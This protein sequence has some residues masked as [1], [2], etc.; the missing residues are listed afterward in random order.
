MDKPI[1][2]M[3]VQSK[4]SFKYDTFT[5]HNSYSISDFGTETIASEDSPKP[6]VYFKNYIFYMHSLVP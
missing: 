6:P 4:A 1:T 5:V 2:N 3:V